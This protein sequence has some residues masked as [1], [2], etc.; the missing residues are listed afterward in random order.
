GSLRDPFGEAAGTDVAGID[1]VYLDTV[2]MAA[3]GKRLGGGE[4]RRIDRAADGE[5]GA[6]RPAA[7]AGD[8]H[9]RTLR[10]RKRGPGGT[11][12]AHMAEEFEGEAVLPVGIAQG[13][14]I[15][16]LGGAGIGD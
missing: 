11:N 4:Q 5:I 2:G 9:R 12:E 3:I 16:A 13:E 14:E 8:D 15:A 7:N 1:R 6:R 10:R